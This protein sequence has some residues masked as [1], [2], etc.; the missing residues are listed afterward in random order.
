MRKFAIA[1]SIAAL[2]LFAARANAQTMGEYATTVG[3]ASGSGSMGTSFAPTNFGSDMG[4]SRTWGTSAQGGSWDERVGSVAAPGAGAD[5]SA[6]AAAISGDSG[7]GQ[8]RW[9]GG[10]LA[11]GGGL[12]DSSS[13]RF[14]TGD[15]FSSGDRF[16][17]RD[18]GSAD[19]FPASSFHDRMGLDNS[20]D[21]GGLDNS[22]SHGGLDNSYNSK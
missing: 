5:F 11:G 22:Y 13:G 19:R 16:A 9:P 21:R 3:V 2:A 15:R 7:G 20:Y 17:A 14:S 12:L 4:G 6:R 18:W 8:S 10:V 1:V